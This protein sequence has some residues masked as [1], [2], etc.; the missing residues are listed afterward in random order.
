MKDQNQ[1]SNTKYRDVTADD[2]KACKGYETISEEMA[3]GIADA[4]RVY[5]EV[6]YGC[7]TERRFA[8]QKAKVFTIPKQESKKAA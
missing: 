7:F 4:I 2:V 1:S 6:I 8:E 3:Q 5:T